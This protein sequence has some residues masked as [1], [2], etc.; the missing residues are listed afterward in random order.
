M[1]TVFLTL[2]SVF[3]RA[4]TAF[5]IFLLASLAVIVLMGVTYRKLGIAMVWYDEVASI[6]LAWLTYYGAALAALKRAH[7]GFPG[8][9]NAMPPLVR[10]PLV[11]LGEVIVIG[12]FALLAWYGYQV[13]DILQGDT[14]VSLPWVPTQL[15][16]SVI[17]IG[18]V[19][20]ILAQIFS[21]PEL[22]AQARGAGVVDAEKQEM[23][24]E[25]EKA[26]KQ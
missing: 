4:L 11:L 6:A 9:V 15:T 10:V 7:I 12:F 20:F 26:M 8:L 14:M 18:A 5:V 13:L 24:K 22:L 17:P 19:L 1:P 16:Q 2:R 21:L 3:D 25:L 23:V